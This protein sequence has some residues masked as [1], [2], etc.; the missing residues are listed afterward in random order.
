M[1]ILPEA[2]WPRDSQGAEGGAPPKK[3][4]RFEGY[5]GEMKG[6]LWLTQAPPTCPRARGFNASKPLVGT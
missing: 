4:E 5:L 3:R 1:N 6:L 2:D